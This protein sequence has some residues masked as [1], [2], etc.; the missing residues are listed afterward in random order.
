[1]LRY[2]YTIVINLIRL[3]EAI[4][5]M[6]DMI[7]KSNDYPDEYDEEYNYGYVKY[8]LASST[9]PTLSFASVF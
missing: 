2:Y 8:E 6:N 1:M 3:L 9:Y 5:T 4:K 7:K